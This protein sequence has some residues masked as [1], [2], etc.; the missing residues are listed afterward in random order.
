[1]NKADL[2]F[3]TRAVI[4]AIKGGRDID[5]IIVQAKMSNP[6]VNELL[7]ISGDY[8]IPVQRVP[9]EKLRRIS[10]KNHQGVIAFVSPI[11]FASLENIIDQ[12]YRE[13]R[14]PFLIMLDRVTDVRNFGAIA[15]TAETAGADALI[16]PTKNAAAIN[17]DAVK[18][19]AGALQHIPVCR[20]QN[21]L[22]TVKYLKDYGIFTAALTEKASESIYS[23]KLLGPLCLILGSEE[24]GITTD[25][26]RVSDFLLKIPMRGKVASLNVSASAAIAIYEVV[27]QRME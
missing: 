19:S 1:M 14:D 5:K 10:S 24:D 7:K 11:S 8:K 15:R 9:P 17:A 21:L 25:L 23:Q 13:G 26:I 20:E 16:V 2:L 6:L 18:T 12:C 4:E 27:R 3:G 22:T